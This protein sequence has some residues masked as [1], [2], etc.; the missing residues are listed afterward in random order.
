MRGEVRGY[1]P[2]FAPVSL[3]VIVAALVAGI[4][5]ARG[6]RS[7]GDAGRSRAGWYG[8]VGLA[9][10]FGGLWAAGRSGD[11]AVAYGVG[12]AIA[13]TLAVMLVMGV[14][15][16]IGRAMGRRG[17]RRGRIPGKYRGTPSVS[18][19]RAS[20]SA[21]FKPIDN[22]TSQVSSSPASSKC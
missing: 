3:I 20:H 19:Y 11:E 10:L 22:G 12:I 21:G 13:V 5:F 6:Y 15:T 1:V 4:A 7:P 17:R 18:C 16:A 8:L 2:G 14:A 9:L